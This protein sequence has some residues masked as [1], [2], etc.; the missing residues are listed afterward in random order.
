[1]KLHLTLVS[2]GD[3]MVFAAFSPAYTVPAPTPISCSISESMR[4]FPLRTKDFFSS[5]ITFRL[6]D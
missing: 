6:L 3:D 5:L 1:M 2:K 4:D